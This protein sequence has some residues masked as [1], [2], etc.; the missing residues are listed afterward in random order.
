MKWMTKKS[1]TLTQNY[2]VI[3]EL[4]KKRDG[5]R[6]GTGEM[7]EQARTHAALTEGLGSVPSTHTGQLTTSYNSS[8]SG[9][10]S[11]FW[12]PHISGIHMVYTD[13][14]THI[15]THKNKTPNIVDSR[16]I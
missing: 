13:T 14:H 2:T 7:A 9:S 12:P 3:L 5:Q 4:D 8:S 1:S 11:S 6:G 10:G 15:Y 16:D